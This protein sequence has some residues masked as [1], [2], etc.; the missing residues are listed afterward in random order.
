MLS[1]CAL[2]ALWFS[3]A[4]GDARVQAVRFFDATAEA[5]VVYEHGYGGEFGE[6][7][8]IA[9]GAAVGD[10]DADGWIDLYVENGDTG[11]NYLFR[12][13][14]D[15]TFEE[16]AAAAGVELVDHS[17][18]GPAF[19]DLNGDGWLDLVV[20]GIGGDRPVVFR[21]QGDGTFE[22]IT[23][24]TGIGVDRDTF[25]V[26]LGDYDRDGLMDLLMS[27]WQSLIGS[28]GAPCTGHL[29]RNAGDGT[30]GTFVD[31]DLAA[32]LFFDGVDHTFTPNLADLDDDGW[33]E[34]L[35]ASDFAT[36]R[37]YSADGDGTFTDVTDPEVITDDNGMGAAVGDYDGDGDL[38]W[39]VTSIRNELSGTQTG[40]R[41]YRNT[42]SGIFEDATDEAGVR[43]GGWGWGACFVDVDNDGSLDLFHTNGWNLPDFEDNRSKLFMNRGDGVFDE[44]SFVS[45]IRDTGQ[46]RGVVCFDYDR[47]GDQDLMVIYS[48]APGV[49]Y[50]NDGGDSGNWADVKL[51]SR[52]SNVHG[53]GARIWL[54]ASGR[55][56]LRELRRGSNFVS[57]QA[58]EAHFGLAES[59]SIDEIRVRWPNGVVNTWS[60][61]EVNRRLEL[62]QTYDSVGLYLDSTFYLRNTNSSG[63]PDA[64]L[65]F[66]PGGGGLTPI[67]GDWDGSGVD[68]VGLYDSARGRFH[69]RTESGKTISFAFGP[70]G[71]NRLP[72]VG[73]WDGDGI[74]TIGLVDRTTYEFALSNENATGAADLVFRVQL[75]GAGAQPV[76]GDWDGDGVDSVG[77]YRKGT[78]ALRTVNADGPPD[79]VFQLLGTPFDARPIV[80]DWS[81]DGVDSVGS[82]TGA[83]GELRLRNELSSGHADAVFEFGPQGVGAIPVAGQWN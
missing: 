76:A 69:L 21:N 37:V 48:G 80:G 30:Y 55:T 74:D 20:G 67:T 65:P 81:G 3:L 23:A 61:L 5:G 9:A 24:E 17:G 58:G 52:G 8:L 83:A 15:G 51:Y 62:R 54:T 4:A 40:N 41:L 10:Y 57:Q 78:F 2:A 16:V 12:N 27:H 71:A 59:D 19:G 64:V 79:L 82:Y 47:D 13:L 14:G 32:G 49:L 28:C 45:G 7:Q 77:L 75:G 63:E 60:D 43:T 25:S 68:T 35:L 6:V 56:Q 38:D 39:F 72:V 22:E 29:W 31:D 44:R 11:P 73:D 36:S 26:A 70:A 46:G 50:R 53:I 33:P 66:G 1:A 42:G 34:L 18:S